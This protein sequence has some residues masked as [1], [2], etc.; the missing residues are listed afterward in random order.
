MVSTSITSNDTEGV[1]A[2]MER[3]KEIL[4]GGGDEVWQAE[5]SHISNLQR[6]RGGLYSRP[7]LY[8]YL[9][10]PIIILMLSSVARDF[11]PTISTLHLG[12]R[13]RS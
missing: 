5:N 6:A 13:Y 7:D 1:R 3:R 2:P 12:I 4:V 11:Q 8:L 10:I 9:K